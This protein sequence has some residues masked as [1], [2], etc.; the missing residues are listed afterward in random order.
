MAFWGR[1][2]RQLNATTISNALTHILV[3]TVCNNYQ[4]LAFRVLYDVQNINTAEELIGVRRRELEISL[5]DM[6]EV[7][8]DLFQLFN[9]GLSIFEG[10]HIFL[11][12]DQWPS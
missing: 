6:T 9:G 1:P 12:F 2:A 3:P 7:S 11:R 8:V 10:L 5:F 4:I